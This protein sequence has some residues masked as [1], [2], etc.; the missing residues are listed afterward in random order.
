M[1][2]GIDF[3]IRLHFP[4]ERFPEPTRYGID[5]QEH[6]RYA[7]GVRKWHTATLAKVGVE[8]P[9]WPWG[10]ALID[11]GLPKTLPYWSTGNPIDRDTRVYTDYHELA[12][13]PDEDGT[14]RSAIYLKGDAFHVEHGQWPVDAGSRVVALIRDLLDL[15]WVFVRHTDPCMTHDEFIAFA[16]WWDAEIVLMNQINDVIEDLDEMETLA[17]VGIIEERPDA[18]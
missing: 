2:S 10:S 11:I 3:R 9:H 5:G 17:D 14:W 12:P 16:E 18:P 13:D 8:L 4:D 1:D 7:R 6:P 15:G